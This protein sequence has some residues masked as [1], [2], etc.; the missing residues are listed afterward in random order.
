LTWLKEVIKDK[1]VTIGCYV[2]LDSEAHVRV[3]LACDAIMKGIYEDRKDKSTV[4]LAFLCTPTDVHL[5]PEEASK[6][7][8]KAHKELRSKI[9]APIGLVNRKM[10]VKNAQPAVEVK[11][12]KYY[13]VDGLVVNQGPNYALA[14]RMQHW[15]A[16]LAY[17]AGCVVS[18][19]VAPST[20]TLSVVHN[21]QFAWAYDGMPFFK[22]MEIFQPATSNA[23][24]AGL[25]IHDISN[26]QAVARPG[27]TVLKNP[28]QLFSYGAFHGGVWRSAYKVGSIG[29]VSAMIHFVKVAR[30]LLLVAILVVFVAIF[31]KMRK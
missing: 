5:V 11:G 18:S 8:H 31:L 17:D 21:R 26:P 15:R 28:Y 9:V 16:I 25:L 12:D 27:L 30:P 24:M 23:V 7:A 3:A 14:K 4:S 13:Y 29:E 19:N 22:P 20:A 2:Y 6:Q 10:L 1:P